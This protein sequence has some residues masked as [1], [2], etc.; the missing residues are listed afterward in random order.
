MGSGATPILLS[1][2][3]PGPIVAGG[4]KVVKMLGLLRK[5]YP[6]ARTALDYR[7]PLEMLISTILSAQCTDKRVNAVTNPL[8]KKY[9]KAQ[10]YL[11]APIKKLEGDIRSTG[12]YHNKAKNIRGTCSVI[13]EKF[14]SKVPRTMDELLQLP[15]VGRKTANIVLYNSYGIIAGIAVDTHAQRTAFRLGLTRN[16]DPDKIERDLMAIVPKKEWGNIT[17]LLISLGR[18]VCRAGAP[19]CANCILNKTCP[20]AF[21]FGSKPIK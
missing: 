8:F 4:A 5:R 9:R 7:S 14:G 18:D 11:K 12:F 17:N 13:I 21:T 1:L 19:D 10:D 3:R 6:G 2:S 16:T 20:S 15:G